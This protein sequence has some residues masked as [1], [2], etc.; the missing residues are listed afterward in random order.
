MLKQQLQFRKRL[1]RFASQVPQTISE[2]EAL[3]LKE[4]LK[5]HV[6][7]RIVGPNIS[8]PFERA[9]KRMAQEG[10]VE[11]TP[12]NPGFASLG[13]WWEITD[14]GRNAL[15]LYQRVMS[16]NYGVRTPYDSKRSRETGIDTWQVLV[17]GQPW[18]WIHNQEGDDHWVVSEGRVPQGS[19]LVHSYN[20]AGKTHTTNLEAVKNWIQRRVNR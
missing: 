12:K 3:L 9:Y 16:G 11:W 1:S 18:G 20:G 10:L 5:P 13:D 7:R 8:V 19:K 17:D 6:Q 15:K 4:L 2:Q 14:K